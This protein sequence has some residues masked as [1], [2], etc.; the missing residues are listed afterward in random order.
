MTILITPTPPI[1][2]QLNEP[3]VI[4]VTVANGP[5][6]LPGA[7]GAD[8]SDGASAYAV[9]VANGFV[10]TEA[11]W[12]ASL[13][14]ADGAQGPQGDTGPTGAT[15]PAGPTG[16]TGPQGPTGSTGATGATGPAGDTGP[17][18]SDGAPG[19]DGDSA[20]AVA[21]ANGFVGT[22][23]EWLTSLIGPQG[24]EGP[25]GE[26]GG[27][28]V[29]SV[30]V[31]VPTGLS[32]A[33]SPITG[34]GT[35]VITFAAGYSIPTDASQSNWN[36]AYGW[37]NHASAGYLTGAAIGSTVQAY[38]AVLAATTA[39]FTTTDETK[40][41]GIEAG[42]T[43]DQSAAEI[44]AALVTVDGAASG[45]DADLLDGQ[46]AAAFAA[47]GHNHAGV[48]EPA[49]A[50]I[51][52]SAAIGVSVQAYSANLDEYAGVNP[53]AAGLALLDDADNTAQRATLGLVIGTDVQAHSA[54]LDAVSGTNTG[55]QLVFKTITVAG[56]SDV[57]ADTAADTLTLVAGTNLAITTN[58]T[59]DTV[60]LT[61]SLTP[62]LDG[63]V[64]NAAGTIVFE[65][66]TADANETTLTA[67][68]PTADRTVTLP[69]ATT[70][71]AGLAVA[72]SFTAEQTF[73]E[74]KDTVHTI[75][76]GAAFEIDPANGSVQVVT[77][78]ANRTPAATNFEAGQAV[79]LG[80]DD[81]TD[82]TVTWTT[83][84]PTWV[85]AGGTGAAPTLATS[86]YTWVL[87]W[88]VGT[89]IYGS[90]GLKP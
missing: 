72:Q 82:Y 3:S 55:D 89:T 39:S 60:T 70:T 71:L 90:E 26:G 75:T 52:K 27:G 64:L 79:L 36:T 12:L 31:T 25:P 74:V 10:G 19:A 48:Y 54:A 30:A 88:K 16:A 29:T 15:G 38:S 2:A 87:L 47:A 86:G 24:P 4:R 41:D 59:T 62:T 51:L 78:G 21:V 18:G 20:Y 69:D 66:T 40:L 33:G 23:A 17:A 81:G 22:E 37:G 8:G 49:D 68:E 84:A 6:G 50:T 83:V 5:R 1:K 32:V 85:K 63:V 46:E 9:A 56:Q 76:D 35:F 28:T 77:L 7:N 57:V 80:I 11:E 58:A 34:A 61:P 65:G 53:T 44:L 43:A 45:L 14:G 42:A 73:K 13:V 67:G